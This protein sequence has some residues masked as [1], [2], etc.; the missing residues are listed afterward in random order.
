MCIRDSSTIYHQHLLNLIEGCQYSDFK[1][2]FHTS[3]LVNSA[4]IVADSEFRGL[5]VALYDDEF[6]N[7]NDKVVSSVLHQQDD[8]RVHQHRRAKKIASTSK[9]RTKYA[10][11]LAYALAYGDAMV[12]HS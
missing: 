5:E 1:D 6:L 10:K 12:A 8:G 3:D 7:E 11:R 2:T 4:F 9:S